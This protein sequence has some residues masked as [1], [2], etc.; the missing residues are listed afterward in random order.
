MVHGFA[1]GF[2]I[3]F[4]V[5]VAGGILYYYLAWN[6]FVDAHNS[7]MEN[8]T[9][10]LEEAAN[11]IDDITGKLK[12]GELVVVQNVEGTEDVDYDDLFVG[13]DLHPVMRFLR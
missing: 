4:V 3:G 1:I 2:M 5:A 12:N 11:C 9:E 8:A 7:S 10:A 13:G 6:R